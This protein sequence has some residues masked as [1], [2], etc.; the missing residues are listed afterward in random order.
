MQKHDFVG[1]QCI[2]TRAIL[3]NKKNMCMIFCGGGAPGALRIREGARALRP[4]VATPL[5]FIVANQI[6]V[7]CFNRQ[8]SESRNEIIPKEVNYAQHY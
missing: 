1:A 7:Y 6:C 8:I 2:Y 4:H 3:A 5:V